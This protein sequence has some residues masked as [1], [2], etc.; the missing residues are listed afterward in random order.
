MCV[1]VLM[2]K[3]GKEVKSD[4]DEMNDLRNIFRICSINDILSVVIRLV[5]FNEL[6][7][8]I[9]LLT[10]TISLHLIRYYE[11]NYV[12]KIHLSEGLS[13]GSN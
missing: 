12:N 8:I 6:I 3:N 9:W 13:P 2:T 7:Q 10:S 4:K 11:L 1:L 5:D